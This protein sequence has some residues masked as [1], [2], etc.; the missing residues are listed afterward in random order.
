M[1]DN[2]TS[3]PCPG[4]EGVSGEPYLLVRCALLL[5]QQVNLFPHSLSGGDA[6]I[7]LTG[8]I[9]KAAPP[10]AQLGLEAESYTIPSTPPDPGNGKRQRMTWPPGERKQLPSRRRRS[11]WKLRS[12]RLLLQKVVKP[13]RQRGA[14]P[15]AGV[16]I[17]AVLPVLSGLT[18]TAALWRGRSAVLPGNLTVCRC[19][20]SHPAQKT[21]RGGH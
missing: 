21:E 7:L 20:S 15:P 12:S 11:A 18:Q 10:S 8:A 16:W 6:R 13:W 2:N 17:F 5:T 9:L 4:C 3:A 1:W 19:V 14:R